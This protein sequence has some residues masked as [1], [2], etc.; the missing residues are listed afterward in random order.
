MSIAVIH[1]IAIF[2]PCY[3]RRKFIPGSTLIILGRLFMSCTAHMNAHFPPSSLHHTHSSLNHN[4]HFTGI[5]CITLCYHPQAQPT[6]LFFVCVNSPNNLHKAKEEI[7]FRE[8]KTL[9]YIIIIIMLG[10]NSVHRIISTGGGW[11]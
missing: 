1:S 9:N 4:R 6:L 5:G 8:M 10:F 3:S 2:G 11:L 7:K